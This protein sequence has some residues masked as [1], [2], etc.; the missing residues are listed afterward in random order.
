MPDGDLFFNST[1]NPG[2]A[3]AGSGDALTGI[4]LGLLCR[5]YNSAHAALIGTYVHGFS[6]DLCLKKMS[7]ESILISDVIKQLP[8]A[9]KKLEKIPKK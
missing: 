9:F 2:L 8:K 5:G 1:G 3:K 4:I 6:A 7:M